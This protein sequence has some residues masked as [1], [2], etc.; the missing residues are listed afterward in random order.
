MSS[1][2]YRRRQLPLTEAERKALAEEVSLAT[3]RLR[4]AGAFDVDFESS[5][6][7][8]AGEAVA[9]VVKWVVI[10]AS[11]TAAL[12]S[13]SNTALA[14]QTMAALRSVAGALASL[15]RYTK[16]IVDRYHIEQKRIKGFIDSVAVQRSLSLLQITHRLGMAT[17]ATYQEQVERV[18]DETGKISRTVFGETSTVIGALNMV[19]LVTQDAFRLNGKDV[20]LA[21]VAVFRSSLDLAEEV[22]KNAGRYARNP[23]SFWNMVQSRYIKPREVE[24]SAGASDTRKRIDGL[25]V[26]IELA[27]GALNALDGRFGEYRKAL[28]PFISVETA[29]E[30]DTIRRNFDIDVIKPIESLRRDID[31]EFPKLR[32]DIVE[33][34]LDSSAQ[35]K[36]IAELSEFQTDP[37]ELDRER[38]RAVSARWRSMIDNTLGFDGVTPEDLQGAQDRIAE[39]HENL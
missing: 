30:L 15:E 23:G 36:E 12:D 7:M 2:S 16:P 27:D 39:I 25:R 37:S 14:Q 4:D 1:P 33:L 31:T 32:D 10:V 5:R 20:N 35:D 22:N 19:Q 28:D 6:F 21:D 8:S 26:G 38:A 29:R 34:A 18:Y 11:A 24:S 13:A 17:S 3:E 9:E